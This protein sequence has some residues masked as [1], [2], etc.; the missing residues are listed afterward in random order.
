MLF[1]HDNTRPMLQFCNVQNAT[2]IQFNGNQ[3]M[4]TWIVVVAATPSGVF[5]VASLLA[6]SV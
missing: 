2:E 6:V 4:V 5:G 1:T 3:G